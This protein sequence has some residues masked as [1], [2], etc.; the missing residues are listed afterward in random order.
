MLRN[1]WPA[2]ELPCGEAW[3]SRLG[4][5]ETMLCIPFCPMYHS[6]GKFRVHFV[7]EWWTMVIRRWLSRSHQWR[8]VSAGDFQGIIHPRLFFNFYSKML[9]W[10]Y[11]AIKFLLRILRQKLLD[12]VLIRKPTYTPQ[13]ISHLNLK[14]Q[15]A[16][17]DWRVTYMPS[18][19]PWTRIPSSFPFLFRNAHTCWQPQEPR[20]L[21]PGIFD[22]QR[23]L[24][25]WARG[26]TN[27]GV[28]RRGFLVSTAHA[29]GL[30]SF[31]RRNVWNSKLRIVSYD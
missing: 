28:P 23:N 10:W 8:V 31:S 5:K 30:G 18:T 24:S 15:H 29:A 16:K 13:F 4:G 17:P 14:P 2:A 19:I 21:T 26:G 25:I 12:I 11:L 27:N 3:L 20:M 9:F 6:I 22:N 7:F 1:G